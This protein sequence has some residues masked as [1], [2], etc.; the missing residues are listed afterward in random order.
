[1]LLITWQL[2]QIQAWAKSDEQY[3]VDFDKA[4]VWIGYSTKG[5]AK[6]ALEAVFKE[7]Q[8]Y[9]VFDSCVKNPIESTGGRPSESIQ[10]T[11]NCFKKFCMM[12]GTEV[13]EAV[14]KYFIR[15]KAHPH[16]PVLGKQFDTRDLCECVSEYKLFM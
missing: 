10:L 5:N 7:G 11:T 6:R 14:R 2:E 4:W 16:Y 9:R 15:R 8:D 12:A 13:G 1:M 3:P